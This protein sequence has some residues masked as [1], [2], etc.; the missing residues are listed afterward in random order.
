MEAVFKINVNMF[1]FTKRQ[2]FLISEWKKHIFTGDWSEHTPATESA[3][4]IISLSVN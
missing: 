2:S 4:F 3:R 1:F